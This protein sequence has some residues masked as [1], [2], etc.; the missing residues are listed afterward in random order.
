MGGRQ[1]VQNL[2]TTPQACEYARTKLPG[3]KMTGQTMREWIT[4]YNLGQKVG[5][6]F[7]VFKDELEKFIDDQLAG[8]PAHYH[9]KDK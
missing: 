5:G 1:K 9:H 8:K 3:W 2:M 6:R 7:M 4:R